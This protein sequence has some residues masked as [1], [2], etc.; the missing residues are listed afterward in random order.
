MFPLLLNSTVS[1]PAMSS[2]DVTTTQ[3]IKHLA[4]RTQIQHQPTN[5]DPN[6]FLVFQAG[7]FLTVSSTNYS[8]FFISAQLVRI[9]TDCGLASV[10]IRKSPKANGT[11]YSFL[12]AQLLSTAIELFELEQNLAVKLSTA[13]RNLALVPSSLYFY[14]AL[15]LNIYWTCPHFLK[16]AWTIISRS[17]LCEGTFFF[18]STSRTYCTFHVTWRGSEVGGTQLCAIFARFQCWEK[19]GIRKVLQWYRSD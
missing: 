8:P 13:D 2:C 6:V 11:Y 17:A 16:P 5:F 15:T 4:G 10:F 12:K 14:K 19:N 1:S 7:L 3:N 9:A 18:L